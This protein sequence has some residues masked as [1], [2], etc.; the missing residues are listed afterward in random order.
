MG[1]LESPYFGI[2]GERGNPLAPGLCEGLPCQDLLSTDLDSIHLESR[3]FAPAL[4]KCSQDT[5][6]Y[7]THST[8][9]SQPTCG[10]RFC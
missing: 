7:S 3:A 4:L 1:S 10:K 6:F 9:Q 5:I 2:Q 8:Q